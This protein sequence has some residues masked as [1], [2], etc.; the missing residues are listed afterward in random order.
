MVHLIALSTHRL[1]CNAASPVRIFD[2]RI[3]LGGN[4]FL[5]HLKRDSALLPNH[6]RR[7]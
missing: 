2:G 7:D 3:Y 6:G 1:G 5:V 4:D